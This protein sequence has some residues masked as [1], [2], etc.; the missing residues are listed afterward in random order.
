MDKNKNTGLKY[1]NLPSC[2][3]CCW[4][5]VFPL[6]NPFNYYTHILI[7]YYT[8]IFDRYQAVTQTYN[9]CAETHFGDGV[10]SPFV[11]PLSAIARALDPTLVGSVALRKGLRRFWLHHRDRRRTLTQAYNNCA[12]THLCGGDMSAFVFPLI[13]IA[14][15]SQLWRHVRMRALA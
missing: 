5:L 9:N 12:E 15:R 6:Y 3:C 1:R 13:A 4:G 10:M 2:Y 14:R 8:F 11:S 7:F